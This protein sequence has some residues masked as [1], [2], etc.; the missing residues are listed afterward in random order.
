VVALAALVGFW[1]IEFGSNMPHCWL[2]K[3]LDC[4]IANLEESVT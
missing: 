3:F 1:P 2:P 4:T